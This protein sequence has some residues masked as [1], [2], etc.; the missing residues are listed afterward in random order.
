MKPPYR[1]KKKSDHDRKIKQYERASFV[2]GWI[3]VIATAIT[4]GFIGWVLRGAV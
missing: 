3:V 2:F 1:F 4:A